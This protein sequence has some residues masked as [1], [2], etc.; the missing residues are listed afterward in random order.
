ME[1][2]SDW[3]AGTHWRDIRMRQVEGKRASLPRSAEQLDFSA[4]QACQLA[5]DCQPEAGPA[6]FATGSGICLL[7]GLEDN[8]LLFLRN[9]D[10]GISN[11]ECDNRA[12]TE[13]RMVLT[14]SIFSFEHGESYAALFRELE[15]V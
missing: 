7:E 9:A 8:L 13:D 6:V 1:G 4:K 11:F 15:C 14:P 3:R 2:L 5:A 12:I 10:S